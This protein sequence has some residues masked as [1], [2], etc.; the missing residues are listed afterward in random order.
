MVTEDGKV[1]VWGGNE[2][3]KLGLGDVDSVSEPTALPMDLP[4][5]CVS[6]GYYHTAVITGNS[7]KFVII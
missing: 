2:D 5:I 7:L 3:G 1:F 6:C 4:V